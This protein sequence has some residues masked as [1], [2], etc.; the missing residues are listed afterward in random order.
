LVGVREGSGM[1]L[2]MVIYGLVMI[3]AMLA[4][5]SLPKMRSLEADLPDYVAEA[6]DDDAAANEVGE[7]GA[8]DVRPETTSKPI[9]A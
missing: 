5:Y 2:V 6:V 7:E 8:G 1:G 9:P 3:V 4:A